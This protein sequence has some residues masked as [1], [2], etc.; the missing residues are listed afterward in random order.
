MKILYVT[1]GCFDKGGISRYNRY[2]VNV[3]R[4]LYG[5]ANVR[6][7]SL[8]GPDANSFEDSFETWWHGN[9]ITLKD[10]MGLVTQVVRLALS[11]KPHVIFVGHVNLSGL[12]WLASKLS[13]AKTILNVYGLEIWSGLSRDAAIG[14]RKS[15]YIISDCH[16]T[17]DYLIKNEIRKANDITVIW[18]CVDIERFVLPQ[19]FDKQALER[20]KI[21]DPST[22]FIILTLGRLSKPDAYYKGYDRL[23]KVFARIKPKYPHA[24][25]VIAGRGNFTTELQHMK[26][27]LGMD[28]EVILT[29]SIDEADIV[30][31]YQ[32][33][34]LFSLV[35]EAGKGKG[36]GIPLTPLEAMACGKPILVGDQDGSRE[37]VVDGA[38]GFVLDPQALD[39]HET[40]IERYITDAS[41]RDS[42]GANA[43]HISRQHF[44]YPVFK[45]KHIEFFDKTFSAK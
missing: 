35:T 11:W 32:S 22:H 6:V 19:A 2:Q 12:C 18:D 15:D 27:E 36:E 25:L 29:G 5:S 45:Q 38:N 7:L 14:L 43:F 16:N 20:Y 37:A 30:S 17:A 33:C 13:G 1:P 42:H 23:M 41:L 31:V 9:G 34:H 39:M 24:R 8:L 10:K 44:S 40:I 28:G 3:L 26:S 4:E 21:P